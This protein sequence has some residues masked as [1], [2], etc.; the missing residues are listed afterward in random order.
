MIAQ[1]LPLSWP[2]N[3]PR[4]P[5]GRRKKN[6]MWKGATVSTACHQ[7]EESVRMLGG[8]DLV[9]STNLAL[10]ID[11]FPRSG[12]PEPSDPGVAVYFHRKGKPLVFACDS[13]GSVRENLRAIGMHLEAMRGM[14]R[15]GCGTL[16]QAFAGYA[17][18]PAPGARPP[19]WEVLG[20]QRDV[21]LS[22]RKVEDMS[23]REVLLREAYR[24]QAKNAHPDAGGSTEAFQSLTKAFEE[25]RTELGIAS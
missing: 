14:E 11:G 12:Q 4:T 25:A 24:K 17:A 20:L 23:T 10:R 3:Q 13:Y 2:T 5:F 8:T 19:W 1:A 15:W 21:A 16:D 7:I 18:L 9:L 22:I 6:P